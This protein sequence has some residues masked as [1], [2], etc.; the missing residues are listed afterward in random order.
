LRA[1]LRH[2]GND[3][4]RTI[5]TARFLVLWSTPTDVDAFERHYRHV[6]IPLAHQMSR[7]LS[8]TVSR[9]LAVVRGDD[10]PY[11][12]GEL[13]WHTMDDLK[14]DFRSPEGRATAEDVGVLSQWSVGVRSFTYEA[15]TTN[16]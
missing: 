4:E 14:A 10:A 8:Y 12:V 5:M 11:I 13:E 16:A 3:P 15:E 7:L 6:H 2:G 9:D 1:T